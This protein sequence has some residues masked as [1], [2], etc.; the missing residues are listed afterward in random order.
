MKFK[1]SYLPNDY[2]S[3]IALGVFGLIAFGIGFFFGKIGKKT[4]TN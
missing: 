3:A 4:T 1:G 2:I